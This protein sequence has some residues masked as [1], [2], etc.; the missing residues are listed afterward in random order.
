MSNQELLFFFALCYLWLIANPNTSSLIF[1]GMVSEFCLECECVDYLLPRSTK[2]V[3][4]SRSCQLLWRL[5]VILFLPFFTVNHNKIIIISIIIF[6]LQ[7]D[8]CNR[9]LYIQYG[10]YWE[11]I[12][13]SSSWGFSQFFPVKGFFC[14]LPHLNQI[15][16]DECGTWW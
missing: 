7:S 1:V 16:D 5:E 11:L 10:I 2:E 8:H 13:P 14:G 4:W 15:S 12:P 3:L 9:S 6:P